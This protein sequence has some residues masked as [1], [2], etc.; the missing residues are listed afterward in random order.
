MAIR[1]LGR[2]PWV[3]E[4]LGRINLG[5]VRAGGTQ[6]RATILGAEQLSHNKYKQS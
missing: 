4:P 2:K 3:T 6:P 5:A 1:G